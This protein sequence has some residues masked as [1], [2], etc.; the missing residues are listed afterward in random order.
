MY[1]P[2]LFI[3]TSSSFIT[4]LYFNGNS[5]GSLDILTN[6]AQPIHADVKTDGLTEKVTPPK[7]TIYQAKSLRKSFP[8]T[9]KLDLVRGISRI[10]TLAVLTVGAA[11][12]FYPFLLN[13]YNVVQELI[14]LNKM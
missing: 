8:L 9:T 12:E 10:I 13:L 2:L 7:D 6:H 14:E 1:L 4:G 3:L 5:V 11:V